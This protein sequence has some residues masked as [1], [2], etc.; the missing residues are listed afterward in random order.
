M[1]K[2]R[3]KLMKEKDIFIVTVTFKSGESINWWKRDRRKHWDVKVFR[4][5]GE[6]V[7]YLTEDFP[8]IEESVNRFNFSKD[9]KEARAQLK[10]KQ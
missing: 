1:P 4:R 9:I 10:P 7:S 6:T 8:S 2:K 5:G 3:S